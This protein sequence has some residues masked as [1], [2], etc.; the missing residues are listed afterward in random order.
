MKAVHWKRHAAPTDSPILARRRQLAGVGAC[1]AVISFLAAY[2]DTTTRILAR[3]SAVL[4]AGAIAL[5]PL[6]GWC[7]AISRGDVS[8]A[9]DL[10]VPATLTC[11]IPLAVWYARPSPWLLAT[12]AFF[13][14]L[15]GYYFAVGMWI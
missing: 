14:F 7:V 12:A 4:V 3:P 15:S 1:L 6:F 5:G 9:L 11:L 13:W 2:S 10:L 8:R